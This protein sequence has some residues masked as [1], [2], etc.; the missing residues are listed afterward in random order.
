VPGD[1]IPVRHADDEFGF[2]RGLY[3]H[4]DLCQNIA[5]GPA[6]YQAKVQRQGGGECTPLICTP[7]ILGSSTPFWDPSYSDYLTQI[8]YR[9]GQLCLLFRVCD[10]REQ[11]SIE[12][13]IRVYIIVDKR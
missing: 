12:S 6:D 9:D 7:L 1:D 10:P 4:R 13:K 8:C 2:D 5:S 11:Q 3:D